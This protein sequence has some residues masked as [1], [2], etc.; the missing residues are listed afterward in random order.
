MSMNCI[1]YISTKEEFRKYM[2]IIIIIMYYYS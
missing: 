1:K 2:G